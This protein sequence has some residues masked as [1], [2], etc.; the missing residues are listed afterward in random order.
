VVKSNI[1]RKAAF[2]SLTGCAVFSSL[3]SQGRDEQAFQPGIETVIVYPD[4]A[5]I[6]RSAQVR[7]PAGR[8]TLSFANASPALDPS[9][10][11]GF[12]GNDAC[13]V[14]SVNSHLERRSETVNPEV[15]ELERNVQNLSREKDEKQLKIDRARQELRAVE[16]Y[17]TYLTRVL[18]EDSI[19][20]RE[21]SS[22]AKWQESL[23]FL[24]TRR[25]NAREA[26]QSSEEDIASINERISIAQNDLNRLRTDETKTVRIV[27][28]TVVC[29]AQTQAKIGFSYI[30]SGASWNVSYGMY[31]NTDNKI[32]VEYYGNITQKT[33]EDWNNVSLSLST[34]VPSQ[35]AQR[36]TV[37]NMIVQARET[38]TR[39]GFQQREE[40]AKPQEQNIVTNEHEGEPST[41]DFTELDRSGASLVFRIQNPALIPSGD[42]S[43]RVTVARFELPVSE[44]SF[45]LYP[46]QSAHLAAKAQ[47]D[48]SFPMLAG[49][50]DVFRQAGFTGRSSITYTPSG[51]SFRV[52]FGADRSIRVRRTVEHFRESGGILSS[53]RVYRTIVRLE[54][55]N[56]NAD[57]RNISVLERVPV[58]E[59]EQVKVEI[60]SQTTANYKEDPPKSGV[61][62]WD[63]NPGAGQKASIVLAYSV[64]V[65]ATYPGEVLGD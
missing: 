48:R 58:S 34:S 22:A 37:A 60:L 54:I 23:N 17:S 30:I 35:G 64:R 63:I 52:G 50:V 16:L 47:N 36:Q 65:P 32:L 53:D 39:E 9:S 59:T 1:V 7:V 18:S 10:L 42:R 40:Q 46:R 21:G 6:T 4:R 62:K 38:H 2:L 28:V 57:S 13:V 27:E 49:S 45:R 24:S 14:Q 12:S 33:G 15:R 55:E 20:T 25:N 61:L 5:L 19:R 29:S 41:G 11:R 43:Q 31:L 51:A 3:F 44:L 26:I 8:S 56:L